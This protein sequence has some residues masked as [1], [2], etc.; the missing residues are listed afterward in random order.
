M[1][2]GSKKMRGTLESVRKKI[3]HYLYEVPMESQLLWCNSDGRNAIKEIDEALSSPPVVCNSCNGSGSPMTC[4]CQPVVEWKNEDFEKACFYYGIEPKVCKVLYTF[5][6][7][8]RGELQH[9]KWMRENVE[10]ENW[11]NYEKVV[12]L[13]AEKA[14]IQ[15]DKDE[16]YRQRNH[17]VASLAKLFPSGTRKTNIPGWDNEWHGCCF[18][19]LPGGQISYH[20]HDSQADLFKDLP[21][22]TKEW[23]GHDKEVV[24][25]RLLSV[26]SLQSKLDEA[27]D[28][29]E[30][31]ADLKVD[32]PSIT[33]CVC[34]CRHEATASETL[35]KVKEK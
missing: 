28:G 13:Q 32:C 22:Y 2:D 16:A 10:K 24:H 6:D 26:E 20:Y 1:T 21:E 23:D 5:I 34:A 8:L 12:A 19:D 25:K 29:L 11:G 7:E 18:I 14:E 3:R 4:T 33:H 9:V 15:R 27:V 31:I 17:L 30:K 35:A